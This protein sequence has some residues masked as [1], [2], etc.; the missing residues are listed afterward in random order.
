MPGI[1]PRGHESSNYIRNFEDEEKC[2]GCGQCVP[3]C[4]EGALQL[5]NGKA[6]LVGELLCDGLGACIGKCPQEALFIEEREVEKYDEKKVM[7]NVVEDV[8]PSS[9]RTEMMFYDP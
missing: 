5:I 9:R 8:C 6:C 2:N 4:P 1:V 3:D 7:D